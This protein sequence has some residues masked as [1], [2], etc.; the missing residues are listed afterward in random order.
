MSVCLA[1]PLSIIPVLLGSATFAF[2]W[3]TSFAEFLTNTKLISERGSISVILIDLCAQLL[4]YLPIASW[5]LILAVLETPV[6][7]R[8]YAHHIGIR[9]LALVRAEFLRHWLAPVLIVAAFAFQDAFNDYIITYLTL[10]PSDATNTELISHFL[11]RTFFSLAIGRD[12][13]EAASVLVGVSLVS[14]V[15]SATIFFII[16]LLIAGAIRVLRISDRVQLRVREVTKSYELPGR[17]SLVGYLPSLVGAL[18]FISLG[19]RIISLDITSMNAVWQLR[20]ALVMSLGVAIVCWCLGVLINFCVREVRS[21]IDGSAQRGLAT[22][23]WISV[24][25]G[26]IPPAGLAAA[27]YTIFFS[28]GVGNVN[29]TVGWFVAEVMR[30]LPLFV[31]LLIPTSLAI[32]GSTN[33]VLTNLRAAFS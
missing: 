32:W 7:T 30:M 3:R 18:I 25:L 2:V 20:Y 19:G 23:A 33:L 1:V 22:V 31:V 8:L 5:F 12:A 29:A 28:V 21:E 13:R 9:P 24:S 27:I 14:G 11:N 17:P 16:A 4:R 6:T 15:F 10:K 26:F